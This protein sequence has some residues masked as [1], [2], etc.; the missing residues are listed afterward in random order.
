MFVKIIYKCF[1]SDKPNLKRCSSCKHMWY[2]SEECHKQGNLYVMFS[3]DL[4]SFLYLDWKYAHKYE[5]RDV[6][7]NNYEELKSAISRILLRLYNV[8]QNNKNLASRK[9]NDF[10]GKSFND[11]PT[12]K[13]KF[14]KDAEELSEFAAICFSFNKCKIKFHKPTMFEYFCKIRVNANYFV[15]RFR[16]GNNYFLYASWT[17]FKHSCVPN[18]LCVV[19]GP[20][21]EIRALKEIKTGEEVCISVIELNQTREDRQKELKKKYFP[22]C[23]CPR[24]TSDFDESKTDMI[25]KFSTYLFFICFR[26]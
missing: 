5:C 25:F 24:C 16:D 23:A 9:V 7:K 8:M 17:S 14:E 20:Q 2:C 1:Y 18:A 21:M 4:F 15:T 12:Y 10:I 19:N 11:L 13:E 3:V 26:I 6:Y 22:E